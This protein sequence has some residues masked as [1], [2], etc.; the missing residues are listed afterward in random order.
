V[1][2]GFA[3]SR[4]GRQVRLSSFDDRCDGLESHHFF[5]DRSWSDQRDNAVQV[6]QERTAGPGVFDQIDGGPMLAGD[7]YNA[8]CVPKTLFALM[9]QNH[10]GN[11]ERKCSNQWMWL[12][13]EKIWRRIGGTDVS[14]QRFRASVDD[15]HP[16]L[17][18]SCCL[19]LATQVEKPA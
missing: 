12:A 2:K 13:F 7:F 6:L 10:A 15:V 9:W 8:L 14:D 16:V 18:H 11:S 5:P 4:A 1:S 19:G 17:L 3:P